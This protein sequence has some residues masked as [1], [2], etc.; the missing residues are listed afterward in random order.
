[1][2][3]LKCDICGNECDSF[4]DLCLDYEHCI[5]HYDACSDCRTIYDSMRR[6]LDMLFATL[7]DLKLAPKKE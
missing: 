7:M 6:S 1:M 5:K 2:K 3:I 4:S